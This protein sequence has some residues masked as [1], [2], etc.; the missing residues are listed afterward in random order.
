MRQIYMV[1]SVWFHICVD[2]SMLG[3]HY[4]RIICTTETHII[5]CGAIIICT[6]ETHIINCGAMLIIHKFYVKRI[7]FLKFEYA[8][9]FGQKVRICFRFLKTLINIS[10]IYIIYSKKPAHIYK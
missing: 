10:N 2:I 9:F 8:F 4:S 6:T 5:N 7:W 3:Y 1:N